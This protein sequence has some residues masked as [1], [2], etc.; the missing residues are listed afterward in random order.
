MKRIE[1]GCPVALSRKLSRLR[2]VSS[3]WCCFEEECAW[4]GRIVSFKNYSQPFVKRN[5]LAAFEEENDFAFFFFESNSS[6]SIIN[7]LQ[8]LPIPGKC[9][10]CPKMLHSPFPSEGVFQL[11]SLLRWPEKEAEWLPHECEIV[12]SIPAVIIL[13]SL[14]PPVCCVSVPTR[15]ILTVLLQVT[16]T[17]FKKQR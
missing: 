17:S 5:K 2:L 8:K 10:W 14:G 12:G 7:S 1:T 15:K 11:F 6:S 4:I 16:L 9:R 13:S 3:E